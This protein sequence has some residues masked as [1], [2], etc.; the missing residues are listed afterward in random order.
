MKISSLIGSCIIFPPIS[1]QAAIDDD[2][3][4]GDHCR[5]GAQEKSG[6]GDI[7]GLAGAFDWYPFDTVLPAKSALIISRLG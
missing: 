3:L 1:G 4:S 5:A 7:L 6:P 2:R